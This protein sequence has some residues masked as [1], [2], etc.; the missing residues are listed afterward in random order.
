MTIDE[1]IDRDPLSLSNDEV[2][3]IVQK[4]REQRKT[5][6]LNEA[7]GKKAPSKKGKTKPSANFKLDL[8][9]LKI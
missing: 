3:L 2:D 5:F 4:L 7:S 8:D 1:L 9:N 6:M